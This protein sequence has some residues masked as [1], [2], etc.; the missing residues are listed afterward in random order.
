MFGKLVTDKAGTNFRHCDSSQLK[1]RSILSCSGNIIRLV[2]GNLLELSEVPDGEVKAC[3]KSARDSG[4][5]IPCSH[6][7]RRPAVHPIRVETKVRIH[8]GEEGG[9]RCLGAHSS[10]WQRQKERYHQAG[11]PN[12]TDSAGFHLTHAS[13]KNR[14]AVQ[15]RG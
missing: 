2:N 15:T 7:H 4:R 12:E 11:R 3:S 9:H 10:W 5:R 14:S 13:S 1:S 8:F 6:W